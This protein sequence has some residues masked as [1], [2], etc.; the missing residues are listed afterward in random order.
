MIEYRMPVREQNSNKGTFGK[1][2][3]FSGSK[4]Y[5]GAA[6]LSTVSIL[7]TGGGFAALATEKD[8]IK[9]V[10]TL[11]PEAVYLTRKEGINQ[12]S[13]FTV[14]LIGCGLGL[15]R[16]SVDL[17]KKV[18]KKLE[19][20]NLTTVID[21]DG[22]NILSKIDIKLPQNIIITPHPL[23]AARLLRVRLNDV[24]SD[25][26]GSAKELSEKYSCITVLK[27]HRT[28]ITDGENLFINQHGNSALAKAGSGDVLSGIISGLLAQI[29]AE[30]R[31]GVN[32]SRNSET[33]KG[34]ID[35]ITLFEMAKLGVYLHSRA[36]E[37]ASEKLTQYSV[38]A[39]DIPNFLHLAIRE[40]L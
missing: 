40:I 31:A 32:K 20:S 26:E 18:I 21:A 27:T 25:L 8:I 23:E 34:G 11:L 24:L 28:I 22:L 12:I 1:V 19:N 6:Y 7:K 14:I 33:G 3:N 36:G 29:A 37:I 17:F 30:N 15:E 39:S 10:S 16:R 35:K 5:I 38:L 2:L 4:N 9:S 13:N